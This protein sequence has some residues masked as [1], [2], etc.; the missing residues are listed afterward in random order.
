M[1]RIEVASGE[2][3]VFRTVDE[4]AT[5]IRNGL[6]T[7]RSRIYHQ[8]SQKWLP[9]EFHP[10]Y[11]KALDVVT[12]G[13]PV[14]DLGP[15]VWPPQASAR[16]SPV[17]APEPRLAS[18]APK[19]PASPPLPPPPP[20][21]AP[22]AVAPAPDIETPPAEVVL[23]KITYPEVP[24][25]LLGETAHPVARR[26]TTGRSPL[27]LA[28]LVV[29]ALIG[30]YIGTSSPMPETEAEQLPATDQIA[31]E[32]EPAK[33]AAVPAVETPEPTAVNAPVLDPAP[34][35]APAAT[36]VTTAAPPPTAAAPKKPVPLPAPRPTGAVS[37]AWSSSAGATAPVPARAVPTPAA[38]VPEPAAIA[39][40][41]AAVEIALPDLPSSDS[42]G[43]TTRAQRDSAAMRRILRAVGGRPGN[44]KASR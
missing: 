21:A 14:I 5:G 28:G 10:H 19:P 29:A 31:A 40:P 8:A 3:T 32:A 13:A 12:G 36:P 1:Y 42:I 17:P 33:P 37:Q 34:T 9:I 43:A 39:P 24:P 35:P 4:L 2:E 27:M 23:P 44:S 18:P 26:R 16:R 41:P 30:G 38:P 22:V 7:P 11:K 6:I 25:P 15:P 20:P